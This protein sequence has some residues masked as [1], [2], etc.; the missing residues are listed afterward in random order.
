[1]FFFVSPSLCYNGVLFV[2]E[3][4]VLIDLVNYT[5]WTLRPPRIIA[6]ITKYQDRQGKR[7]I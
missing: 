3:L 7:G 2:T 5:S 1:M 6:L 4:A